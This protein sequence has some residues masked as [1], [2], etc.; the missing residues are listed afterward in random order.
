LLAAEGHVVP[1]GIMMKFIT[2]VILIVL[3]TCAISFSNEFRPTICRSND[4]EIYFRKLSG[5][6]V[7]VFA[8][9]PKKGLYFIEVFAEP[10]DISKF[11]KNILES[12]LKV[13]DISVYQEK[14]KIGS[15]V[16]MVEF[17]Y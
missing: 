12:D 11:K 9:C 3:S 15:Q 2:I 6:D 13:V 14:T 7:N 16:L 4:D 17:E 5:P 1:L 10:K 8:V